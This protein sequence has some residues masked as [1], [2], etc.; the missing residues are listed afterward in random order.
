MMDTMSCAP[1]AKTSYANK[2]PE[3]KKG[4]CTRVVGECQLSLLWLQSGF[5]EG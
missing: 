1:G 5:A 3:H 2:A 4:T